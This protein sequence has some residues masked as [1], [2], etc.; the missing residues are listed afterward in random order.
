MGPNAIAA[1]MRTTVARRSSSAAERALRRR[2]K[3]GWQ[4]SRFQR[5]LE[6]KAEIRSN[7]MWWRGSRIVKGTSSVWSV[8][9]SILALLAVV[10]LIA[11]NISDPI[12]RR[13]IAVIGTIACLGSPGGLACIYWLGSSRFRKQWSDYR[14]GG[15]PPGYSPGAP[16]QASPV[17]KNLQE[18]TDHY[19]GKN[20]I[21]GSHSEDFQRKLKEEM[22]GS[23][24][25]IYGAADPFLKC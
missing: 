9:L 7:Q 23:V 15:P 19:L 6:E 18:Y 11:M 24:A 4:P 21:L 12:W 8:M 22:Y 1:W 2:A 13:S 5:P 25:A 16:W 14:R 20:S 10:W 17:G 3:S